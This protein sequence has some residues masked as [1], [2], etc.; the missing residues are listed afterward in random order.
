M[1]EKQFAHQENFVFISSTNSTG[2]IDFEII[3]RVFKRLL[4][5]SHTINIVVFLFRPQ[6]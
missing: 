4:L 6:N 2:D 5:Y 3:V 1:S